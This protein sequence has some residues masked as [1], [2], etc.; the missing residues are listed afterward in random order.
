MR[1]CRFTS[2]FRVGLLALP[3]LAVGCAEAPKPTV[4]SGPPHLVL[5]PAQFA[6]LPGWSSD[7]VSEALVALNRTCQRLVKLPEDTSIGPT[8]SGGIAADWYGPCGA[9][10]RIAPGDDAAARA[11]FQEWFRPWQVSNYDDP[12]GVFTGYYEAELNGSFTPSPRYTVP[13]LGKPSD[14]GKRKPY[15]TRAALEAGAWRGVATPVLWVDDPVE[16]HILHI[17]GSGRVKMP[18][19]SLVRLRVAGTN[20]HDFVGIGRILREEG[21]LKGDTSM[22]A[23]RAWLRD[24][25]E[26]AKVLMAKN[27]RYVFYRLAPELKPEEGPIG[28]E[29]VPLTPLRS[30]AVDTSLLPLGVPVWLDTKDPDGK[31][32][33]RLMMAQDTGSAI[34]G[35]VRGDVF[36]G[37]G[38]QPFQIAGRMKSPGRYWLLL[39]RQRSPRVA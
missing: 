16:A 28:A 2:L 21:V 33:Q 27:P 11:Y 1:Q 4:P 20:G 6:D 9:A 23:V 29:G 19:G 30:L 37:A 38:E 32:L 17:Q 14:L 13:I 5:T 31:P 3:L 26:R 34:K 15:H 39:P 18:D 12:T 22:P 8:G 24:N 7:R 10:K 35:P 36:W 25:P